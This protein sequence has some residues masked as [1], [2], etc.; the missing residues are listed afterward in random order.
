MSVAPSLVASSSFAGSVS[1]AMMRPAPAIA[2]PLIA[3]RPMPPQPITATVSPGSTLAVLNTAPTPVITPQ[4]ISA[5][6][7]SGMSSRIF[8]TAFSCTSI[9]SAKD[10]RLMNWWIGSA[11]SRSRRVV[12]RRQ[13]DLGVGAERR[14]ARQ[15]LLAV[16]A[17]HRQAGDDVVAGLDVGDVGAD[18]LD[19]AGR[20]VAE[21]GGQRVRVQPL[22]EVQVGV[23]QPGAGR[24]HQH[25]ARSWLAQADILDDQRLVHFVQD[26]GLHV[27]ILPRT[28]VIG[29]L[30]DGGKHHLFRIPVLATWRLAVNSRRHNPGPAAGPLDRGVAARGCLGRTAGKQGRAR[31]WMA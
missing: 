14:P 12:A 17:E 11:F 18:L 21:H 1:T 19:D 5:A 15:A 29:C 23:A 16:A 4:P 20:L 22:D 8:T 28:L 27:S 25:L 24:A 30:L 13:L 7:S 2:A 9:C 3:D 26:G 6:R 10:D 31:C